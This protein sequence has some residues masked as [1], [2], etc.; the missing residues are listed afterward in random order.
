MPVMHAAKSVTPHPR[1]SHV[2][3]PLYNPGAS[4][5]L[6]VL[7]C[8]FRSCARA[9]GVVRRVRGALSVARAGALEPVRRDVEGGSSDH[10]RVVV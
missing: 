3:G 10:H 4:K 7:Q 5:F 9:H 2:H 8:Y 6:L 1:I